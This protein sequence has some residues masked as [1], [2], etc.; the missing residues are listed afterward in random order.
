MFSAWPSSHSPHLS[1]LLPHPSFLSFI[2]NPTPL[3]SASHRILCRRLPRGRISCLSPIGPRGRHCR[4][5]PVLPTA[6]KPVSERPSW[7]VWVGPPDNSA[8]RTLK[9]TLQQLNGQYARL[10]RRRLGYNCAPESP[11]LGISPWE[12]PSGNSLEAGL[13]LPCCATYRGSDGEP[14]DPPPLLANWRLSLMPF[15]SNVLACSYVC[16]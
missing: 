12:Q 3:K 6:H 8:P 15:Y 10:S 2:P 11:V 1:F 7:Y 16:T 14:R 9:G 4:S 13:D 5:R